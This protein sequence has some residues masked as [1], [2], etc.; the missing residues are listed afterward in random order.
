M[1]PS[2]LTYL[3]K[4]LVSTNPHRPHIFHQACQW[5]TVGRQIHKEV[6]LWRP[7]CK[8][9]PTLFFPLFLSEVFF[10]R[11][12]LKII[13]PFSWTHATKFGFLAFQNSKRNRCPYYKKSV[14]SQS[15]TAQEKAP[16]KPRH[17]YRD[18]YECVYSKREFTKDIF[19]R[20]TQKIGSVFVKQLNFSY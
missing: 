14:V 17:F 8:T 1:S 5:G 18:R 13:W 4:E 15:H 7:H 9:P 12:A 19:L 20:D 16:K 11:K 3:P 10:M 2:P 6:T